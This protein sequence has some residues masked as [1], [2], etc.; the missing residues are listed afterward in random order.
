LNTSHWSLTRRQLVVVGGSLT[1]LAILLGVGGAWFIEDVAER[2]SDRMLAASVRSITDTIRAERG[3]VSLELPPG[4]FGMLEDN[5]RDNVYYSVHHGSRFLT[6]YRDFPNPVGTGASNGSTGFRY[7]DYLDQRVRVVTEVRQ[8]PQLRDPVVVQ[9][10]ETLDERGALARSMLLG[11]ALLEATL[12]GFAIFLLRPAIRW[13]L[14]PVA[15]VQSQI[16]ARDPDKIDF[17]PLT[18]ADV[19]PEL[20]G[21]ILGFNNLLGQLGQATERSRRFTAD[22]SHQL[23][24]PL[25]ALRA[26]VELLQRRSTNDAQQMATIAD[27]RE[28]TERLQRL[29]TQLLALARAE[30]EEDGL[31]ANLCDARAVIQNLCM[32]LAPGAAA[33]GVELHFRADLSFTVKLPA[34]LLEEMVSNLI[35]NAVRYGGAGGEVTVELKRAP[36]RNVISI[37]DTGP[38]IPVEHQPL[39]TQR[40]F[41]LPRDQHLSGSGLGLSIAST[42]AHRAGGKIEFVSRTSSQPFTVVIAIPSTD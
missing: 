20:S 2:M 6:G 34:I 13:G 36:D 40:F 9:V 4:A 5:A 3:Q 42:L 19:T 29:L 23:R 38:G 22:A 28:A 18:T 41:R 10:A 12:V 33:A 39:A 25:A 8:L 15:A 26:H 24:T 14:R 11:L 17:T 16:A 27:I 31:I 30:Q 1:L 7:D 35:E 37:S 32:R 21:L